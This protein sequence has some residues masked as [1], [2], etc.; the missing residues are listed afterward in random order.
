MERSPKP[1]RSGLER[2]AG[3]S[4]LGRV[5]VGDANVMRWDGADSDS[6]PPVAQTRP[7]FRFHLVAL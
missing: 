4:W 2:K 6:S 1:P 3:V 7:E 5:Y